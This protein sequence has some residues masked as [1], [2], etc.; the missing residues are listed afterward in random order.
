ME[1]FSLKP[2]AMML[3]VPEKNG[4]KYLGQYWQ[5]NRNVDLHDLSTVVWQD[6]AREEGSPRGAACAQTALAMPSRPALLS[7]IYLL[8]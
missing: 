6:W 7:P 1:D 3:I 5:N 8:Y 4:I 2:R